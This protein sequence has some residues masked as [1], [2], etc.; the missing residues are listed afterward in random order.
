MSSIYL[1]DH[2]RS[3]TLRP[4]DTPLSVVLDGWQA[5]SVII[6]NYSSQYLYIPNAPKFIDPGTRHAIVSVPS[7]GIALAQYQ[8]PPGQLQPP[9]GP[10]DVC[11]LTFF[12]QNQPAQAGIPTSIGL[13]D[14]L[15]TI[16]VVGTNPVTF[17]V[18]VPPETLAIGYSIRFSNSLVIPS[19][20]LFT[21]HTSQNAYSP[22][23][24]ASA[25]GAFPL[26]LVDNQL[27]I[28]LASISA[29]NPCMVDILAYR[30]MPSF[31]VPLS[32][33]ATAW[34]YVENTLAALNGTSLV[35]FPPSGTISTF[36]FNWELSL[37]GSGMIALRD[38]GF[39]SPN[40][41]FAFLDSA[42]ALSLPGNSGGVP[43]SGG[44]KILIDTNSAAGVTGR[45]F[46][47]YSFA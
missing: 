6:D 24:P 19:E 46:L 23:F 39:T 17:P 14:Y 13:G 8:A 42:G 2:Q 15:T 25:F 44:S 9:A 47:A 35:G 16:T 26:N 20:L 40:G 27:D 22:S 28:S 32:N 7:S 4:T 18:P 37:T 12:E 21:G 41:R 31:A 29:V 33:K 5:N 36:V 11:F 10:N 43:I 38:G 30:E 3:F 1:S 34:S 45:V